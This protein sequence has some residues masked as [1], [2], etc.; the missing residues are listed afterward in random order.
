MHIRQAPILDFTRAGVQ[1]ISKGHR[2]SSSEAG[3]VWGGGCAP[4]PENF[5]I[6]YIKIVSFYAFPEIF[7]D[8]VTALTACFEHIFF[9]KGTLIQKADNRTL[10]TPPGSATGLLVATLPHHVHLPSL[11]STRLYFF[12]FHS[13]F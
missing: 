11:L 4:C 9:K 7:I 1:S 10:W 3:E 13:C 6:S 12:L 2:R 5:C 8:T